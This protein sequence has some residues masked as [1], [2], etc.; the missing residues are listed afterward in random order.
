MK[1][2]DELFP[3]PI[4]PTLFLWVNGWEE[5]EDGEGVWECEAA[6]EGDANY[7]TFET[8]AAL[9]LTH[10]F[11][12]WL[13]AGATVDRPGFADLLD[14]M[15]DHY[16]SLRLV[17][18]DDFKTESKLQERIAAAVKDGLLPNLSMQRTIYE[19]PA[20]PTYQTLAMF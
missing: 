10:D 13:V 16:Q 1:T 3:P 5:L 20:P 8:D 12:D 11:V 17:H 19:M 14:G 4:N 9:F 2:K 15:S 7:G 18:D 6:D